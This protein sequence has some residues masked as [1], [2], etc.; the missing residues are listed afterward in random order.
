MKIRSQKVI[1][2]FITILAV[3]GYCFEHADIAFA[4]KTRNTLWG[5]KSETN[6]VYLLGSLHLLKSENYPVDPQIEFA[7]RDSQVIVFEFDLREMEQQK[8][9][10]LMFKK[11]TL[12][13]GESLKNRL[14]NETYTLAHKK[15]AQLGLD[16]AAFQQLKP[17]LFSITITMMELQRLGFNP[18]FGLDKYLFA[19]AI[20]TNKRIMGLETIEYQIDLF[21]RLPEKTQ[22]AL[23]MQTLRDFDVI[24]EQ[25][26]SMIEAWSVGDLV[27]LEA[28][29]HENL[30]EF[31]A[32][33]EA[34]FSRRNKN[35]I[36]KIESL[37]GKP[38]HYMVVIGAGHL[39]GD[40]GILEMLRRKGYI[41][42]QL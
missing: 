28:L 29:L 1:R 41:L 3:L 2:I 25:A 6:V 8:N 35:W 20:K 11:G 22:D 16:I 9:Q 15:C 14:S 10:E 26:S 18:Q 34:L 37:F 24:E 5:I 23:V 13:Q 21:D 4:G 30:K 40:G 38:E 36:S 42:E 27:K 39:V 7:F 32:I 33:Y 19:K 31:P 17:W 12:P